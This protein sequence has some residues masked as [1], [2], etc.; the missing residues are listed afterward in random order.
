MNTSRPYSNSI[1]EVAANFAALSFFSSFV[2]N[3]AANFAELPF[4]SRNF[5]TAE[6]FGA[7]T[8]INLVSKSKMYDNRIDA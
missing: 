6:F 5:A 2:V 8:L 1:F 3:F 7:I 4:F